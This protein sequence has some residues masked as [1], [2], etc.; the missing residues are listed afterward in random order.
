MTLPQERSSAN[1][2]NVKVHQL[3]GEIQI[4]PILRLVEYLQYQVVELLTN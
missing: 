2:L 1:E 4:Q 3:E